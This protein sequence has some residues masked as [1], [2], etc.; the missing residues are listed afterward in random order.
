MADIRQSLAAED[1]V[2]KFHGL[3]K[4]RLVET[5]K[6]RDELAEPASNSLTF[7]VG[8]DVTILSL[9]RDGE[10]EELLENDRARIRIGNVTAVVEL[11]N[12]KKSS[13]DYSDLSLNKKYTDSVETVESPEIHLRG[14]T[15]DEAMSGLEQ[16]LDRAVLAGLNQIY[17]IHGK[18]E[19][20][21]RRTLTEY[22]K[23]RP[24]VESL[25]IGDWNEGGAG[26]T[27]VKL[28]D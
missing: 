17:V 20:I 27:I 5:Q 21:L 8:D 28:K 3:L 23:S 4:D 1:S 19:G 7:V 22:L 24:E 10:I 16:Y 6:R 9:D 14:M 18:G 2:K 26:V 11:R 12:L 25:R 15:V 13:H